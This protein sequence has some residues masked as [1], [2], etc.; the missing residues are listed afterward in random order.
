MTAFM[1]R[2][3]RTNIRDFVL[4]VA[5]VAASAGTSSVACA[6]QALSRDSTSVAAAG[7]QDAALPRVPELLRVHGPDPDLVGIR[8]AAFSGQVL[9]V[10]ARPSP[11]VFV[12]EPEGN[13]RKWGNRGEGPSELADPQ[14]IVWMHGDLLI[15]DFDLGKIASFDVEGRLRTTR[16]ISGSVRRLAHSAGDTL[17]TRFTVA[18][19][20]SVVRLRSSAETG[21]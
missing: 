12:F 15:F 4:V 6:E 21:C 17:I 5:V 20:H 8:D 3:N 2:G 9:A 7:H 11:A 18:G 10:L 14:S 19:A 16:P 13:T 1:P